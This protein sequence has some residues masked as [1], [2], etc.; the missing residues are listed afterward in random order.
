MIKKKT[1][2]ILGAGFSGAAGMP[3][4]NDLASLIFDYLQK[5]DEDAAEWINHIKRTISWLD[6][7]LVTKSDSINIEEFFD[8]AYFDAMSYS[9]R[10]QLYK[11]GRY[12]GDTPWTMKKSIEAW[13]S[14]MEE[15]LINIIWK[16]QNECTQDNLIYMNDFC[17]K[18]DPDHDIVLTFNYDTLL[19]K[20][21]SEIAKD[22]QHGFKLE[23]GKGI[24]I[25]KMHGS[26]D[27]LTMDRDNVNN[28]KSSAI[29]LLFRKTDLNANNTKPDEWEYKNELTRI[30]PNR[31]QAAI[32][33]RHL[34]R[35][36][37]FNNIGIAG[38]GR[39]KP[40]DLI[41]GL[42]E[43]WAKGLN[44][45]YQADEIYIIGF[46]LPP[47]DQMAR[48]QFAGVMQARKENNISEPKITIIN[49][50]ANELKDRYARVFGCNQIQI[51]TEPAE[52]VNWNTIFSN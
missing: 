49:P 40:L 9:M 31:I 22:W 4:G 41:V 3:L 12:A 46:S 51:N 19:E 37:A 44:A 50:S 11:L 1:V 36:R 33:G 29:T 23:N 30:H 10:Q 16:K 39:H 34:Q 15:D 24:K 13:L 45:L 25:F 20:S 7:Q 2:F 42:G 21:L 5:N 47:T 32:E 18:L 17:K 14:Y 43:V 28:F 27:W 48:L 38:L 52:K 35:G 6:K 8:L 26:I